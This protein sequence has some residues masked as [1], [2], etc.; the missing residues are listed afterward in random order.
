M[1]ISIE[2]SQRPVHCRAVACAHNDAR[3]PSISA[4]SAGLA[5]DL[6]LPATAWVRVSCFALWTHRGYQRSTSPPSGPSGSSRLSNWSTPPMRTAPPSCHGHRALLA[7]L[8][9]TARG[10]ARLG[11]RGC[12]LGVPGHRD[13]RVATVCE[14]WAVR[15][16][17]CRGCG[18]SGT[19][20]QLLAVLAVVL[21]HARCR[22]SA[23]GI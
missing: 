19:G 7:G 17:A 13:R 18:R 16:P 14:G 20:A 4:G 9:P 21:T 1:L 5:A 6:V 10:K 8:P 12:H 23:E 3:S 11:N 15:H 2:P 22:R